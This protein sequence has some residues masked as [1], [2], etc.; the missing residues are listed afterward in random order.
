MQDTTATIPTFA[1]RLSGNV[2]EAEPNPKTRYARVNADGSTTITDAT[3]HVVSGPELSPTYSLAVAPSPAVTPSDAANGAT[4]ALVTFLKEF[5][6]KGPDDA[7][8][9][10]VAVTDEALARRLA[11]DLGK[12]VAY[13]LELARLAGISPSSL[14]RAVGEALADMR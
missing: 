11:D 10:Q 13:E 3:L 14:E 4:R 2:P 7:R 6:P 5:G 9:T 1:E 12:A 8:P